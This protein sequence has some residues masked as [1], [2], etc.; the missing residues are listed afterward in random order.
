MHSTSRLK[1][2]DI[3]MESKRKKIKKLSAYQKA[4]NAKR[5][6]TAYNKTQVY[7]GSAYADF[8]NHMRACGHAGGSV[9]FFVKHLLAVHEQYC[10]IFQTKKMEVLR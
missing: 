7:L 2:V 3:K 4:L 5:C 9:S 1:S 10:S 8:K 6:R